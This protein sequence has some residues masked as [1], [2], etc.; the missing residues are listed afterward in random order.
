VLSLR[1]DRRGD[2]RAVIGR[3]YEVVWRGNSGEAMAIGDSYPR[4]VEA[5][6][7]SGADR[8]GLVEALAK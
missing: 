7:E 4:A 5:I 3:P 6:Y 2:I 8:D 1:H